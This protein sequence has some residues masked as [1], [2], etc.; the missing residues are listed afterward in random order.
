MKH[1]VKFIV[2]LLLIASASG[3]GT[4]G[5][6]T[7]EAYRS[8]PMG[9]SVSLTMPAE[10]LRQ[11]K[12]AGFDYV[13]VTL[14]SLRGKSFEERLAAIERFRADAEQAGLT[15]W[16][17]HLPFGRAWD[18]SSPND[19]L[20][21]AVVGQI[22]WFIDA[23]QAFKPR[24]M[25]LHPSAEPITDSLRAVHFE[26][27]VNSINTLAEAARG[28]DAQLLIEDL[29]RTCLCNTSD[30]MLALF[31]RIDPS[32][33]ICFDTNHLLQETPEAFARAVGGRIASLH[34][35]DYDAVDEKHWTMGKGV[36][37]WP[38]LIGAIASTG[39][40][41]V[42]MFE[43]GGYDSFRQV[44]DTWRAMESRLEE[45][46]KIGNKNQQL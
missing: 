42:F 30:E 44:A 15:V 29:P 13:E 46:E 3:C 41:G 14:N 32:V 8:W 4:A 43:V 45:I 37:D 12:D 9:L 20:R 24:K 40:D 39:Y 2:F 18:I 22:A 38:V 28:T 36:I 11:V 21:T 34:I 5:R 16:S 35:S 10:K 25:V 6:S 33:G 26:N 31:G 23:V 7:L 27:S 1:T 17:V 19:S